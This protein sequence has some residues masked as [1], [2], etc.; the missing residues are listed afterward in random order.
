MVLTLRMV[1]GFALGFLKHDKVLSWEFVCNALFHFQVS[2]GI[3]SAVFEVGK[4][5]KAVKV[6]VSSLLVSI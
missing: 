6:L 2:D 5:I 1:V 3:R 4:Y